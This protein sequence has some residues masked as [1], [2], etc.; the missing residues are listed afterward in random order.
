MRHRI[1]LSLSDILTLQD[2]VALALI[3]MV[4]SS[5]HLNIQNITTVEF[6]EVDAIKNGTQGSLKINFYEDATIP[7][8]ST[9][10]NGDFSSTMFELSA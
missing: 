10:V 4:W 5:L 8:T 3:V 7:G 2:A 1:N 9:F 6:G